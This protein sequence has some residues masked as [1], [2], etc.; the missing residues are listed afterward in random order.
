MCFNLLKKKEKKNTENKI[1]EQIL[2]EMASRK[3]Y[4]SKLGLSEHYRAAISMLKSQGFQ[5][6]PELEQKFNNLY[7]SLENDMNDQLAEMLAE[8]K[9]E[10]DNVKQKRILGDYVLR[11]AI[12]KDAKIVIKPEIDEL[13]EEISKGYQN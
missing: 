4:K 2:N 6:K 13:Y 3:D 1:L 8:A 11:Y 12:V 10:K 9:S 7:V 5:I